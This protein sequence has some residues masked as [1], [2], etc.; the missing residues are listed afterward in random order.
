MTNFQK[1]EVE[2]KYPRKYQRTYMFEN[3]KEPSEF[4]PSDPRFGSGPSLIP[5]EFVQRLADTGVH[6]LGTSHRKQPVKDLVKGIQE[7]P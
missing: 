5:V 7:A 1:V 2:L 3:Y 6:L 4:I